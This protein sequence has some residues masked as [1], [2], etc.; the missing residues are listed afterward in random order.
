MQCNV[1]NQTAILKSHTE[2]LYVSSTLTH[3]GRR[4]GNRILLLS[5]GSEWF[6]DA[7]AG[8]NRGEE[9]GLTSVYEGTEP[10]KEATQAQSFSR[11]ISQ[12][13]LGPHAEG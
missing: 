2:I 5:A 7:V 3:S 11:I 9:T 6:F 12:G 1:E 4:E 10:E 13:A 8:H